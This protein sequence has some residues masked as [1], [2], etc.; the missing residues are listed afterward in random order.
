MANDEKKKKDAQVE[1]L[2]NNRV[3]LEIDVSAEEFEQGLDHAYDKIK[4]EV[5]IEGFRKGNVPRPV[6]EQHKGVENLYEDAL[7]HV[8]QET[9]TDVV[10]G[11]ELPVV[12]QPKI[13]LDVNKVQKGSPFTY[14]ATVA[15]RPSVKL[16]QYKG[17][18]MERPSETVTE[19]EIDKEIE[20][21]REQNAELVVKDDAVVEDGMTA[22]F[23]F[24][25]YID[26]EPFEGG[27][28]ENHELEI[29]SGRFIP[30]FEEQM[31]GMSPG[32]EKEI[33]VTF[34]E[35]YQAEHLAGKEAT[36]EVKL[37]ELKQ[38]QIPELNDEFVEDL[39]RENV[40]TVEELRQD[41]E[42]ELREQKQKANENKLVDFAVEQASQNAEMEI[43]E[44][45]VEEEKNRMMDRTKQQAQQYGI[46]LDT[47]LQLTGQDKEQFEN[48]LKTDAERS[49]RYNLTID[50]IS[51]EE[52][53]DASEEE[54]EAKYQE[55]AEQHNMDVEQV[56]EQVQDSAVKQEVVFRKTIDM[57]VDELELKDPESEETGENEE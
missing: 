7:N 25:G 2:G 26:G 53:I 56:R 8:I 21:L 27:E 42:R 10:L 32:E 14:T 36:F 22:V 31:K 47:Y 43:P 49:I 24:K 15:V 17:F 6:Y 11:E 35:D 13:D 3:K 34:P 46:D 29:G 55:L 18:E 4:D 39:D 1:D 23:D 9:Y 41:I 12:S 44:E 48:K 50:A 19:E 30:G 28:A 52:G 37:H 38:K 57:L 20:Q 33:T 54:V 40:S 5:E 16:G 51:K 45:M